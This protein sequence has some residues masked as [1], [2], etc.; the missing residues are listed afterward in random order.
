MLLAT[1]IGNT[2][3]VFGMFEGP[4]LLKSWRIATLPVRTEDE[5][6]AYISVFCRYEGWD[7]R[8]IDA[9]VITSV[10]PQQSGVHQRMGMKYLGVQPVMVSSALPLGITIVYEDPSAVG[11]DRLCNAVAAHAKYKG[12]TVVIDFGTATTYDVISRKGEYLGG[13][14]APGIETASSDLQK[15]T[16]QLPS[17][18]LQVPSSVIGRNTGESM[19]SGIMFGA[20]DAMEGM[21]R[22]ISKSLRIKPTIVA[23][24]GFAKLMATQ[25]PLIEH[26]E[27][28]FVL[29]GARL[30]YER[31]IA[32]VKVR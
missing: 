10:V 32:G 20:V 27:P 11:A 9:S 30:I 3:T 2:H 26:L 18:I 4:R 6:W 25:S 24:G 12:P 7:A 15:K 17:V 23:T 5:L 16:A 21:I 29:E 19:R 28:D 22:R 8:A 13:V 14:I 31:A 1:D